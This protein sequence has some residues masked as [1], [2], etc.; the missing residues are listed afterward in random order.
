[1]S[2][3][4]VVMEQKMEWLYLAIKGNLSEHVTLML[5]HDGQKKDQLWKG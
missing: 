3:G 5:R 1:M 4:G 2:G